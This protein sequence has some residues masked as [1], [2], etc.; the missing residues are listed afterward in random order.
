MKG[1]RKIQTLAER[2]KYPCKCASRCCRGVATKAGHSPYCARCRTH[3]WRERF[4]LHYS[5]NNLRKRARQRGKDFSLT[6]E[7][8][9]LWAEKTDYARLKGRTSLSLTI[10]RQDNNQGYHAWNIRTMTL[11]ENSRK[12]HVPF[13][14]RQQE[15]ESHEPTAEE[16]AAVEKSIRESENESPYEN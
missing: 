14:A 10:D 4:P 11:R 12:Q 6:R 16:I 7:F 2:R 1:R 15:N 9:V 8:Y 13:F 3:R 5:F